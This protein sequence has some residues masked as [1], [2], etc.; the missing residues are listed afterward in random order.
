MSTEER[1]SKDFWLSWSRK[2]HQRAPWL[3]TSVAQLYWQW[4]P[5]S[6]AV[7]GVEFLRLMRVDR[8]IGTYLLLWPTLWA[9]ILASHGAPMLSE[10]LVFSLGTFLMRSAGCV[11]NDIADRKLDGHVSRTRTRPLARKTVT[12]QEAIGLFVVLALLAFALVLTLNLLT[13]QLSFVA[14]GIASLYPYM[15]RYTYFPQLILGAAFAW[16]IPM[17]Y[18]AVSAS[19]PAEAWLMYISTLLW[20]L[21]YDTYY[22]MVDRHD[23]IK[24]GIKSTAILFGDADLPIIAMIQGFFIFGMLLLGTRND[25]SWPYYLSLLI[26]VGFMVYQYWICRKRQ[27]EQ[28]FRAFL[29]NNY[30]GLVITLGIIAH[31]LLQ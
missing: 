12:T 20:V 17:A 8:P 24:I 4:V 11:I 3:F 7:K 23:D 5:Q 28:C 29:N 9:L 1:T 2:L 19:I 13:V 22:G 25:L 14:I 15:K 21:A 27:P 6:I 30:V 10:L 26:S 31:Y 16:S 18:A